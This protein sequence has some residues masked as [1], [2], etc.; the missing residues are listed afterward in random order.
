MPQACNLTT[1]EIEAERSAGNGGQ[2]SVDMSSHPDS[3]G[4]HS[5]IMQQTKAKSN[6]VCP[7]QVGGIDFSL[8]QQI[9]WCVQYFLM[10]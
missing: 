2:P 8:C 4:L 10:P 6:T 3:Q 9:A 1:Q 5:K 7:G